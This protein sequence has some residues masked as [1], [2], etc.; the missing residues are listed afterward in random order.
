MKA[1]DT[2]DCGSMS[3]LGHA[4]THLGRLD[5]AEPLLEKATEDARRSLG[6]DDHLTLTATGYLANYYETRNRSADA[7][8][9][10]RSLV[11][12]LRLARGPKHPKTLAAMN[13]LGTYSSRP[14][15][16]R[17]GGTTIPRMPRA[18]PRNAWTAPSR[19]TH[20]PL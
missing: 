2:I 6:P 15:Q 20:G 16:A 10:Y 18:Q 14:E 4:L 11:S 17:G 5:E 7:D 8:R 12:D 13:N 19:D 3:G 9:L 1:T